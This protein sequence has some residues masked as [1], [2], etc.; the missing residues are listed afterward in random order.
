VSV[1]SYLHVLHLVREAHLG[2][3]LGNDLI[4]HIRRQLGRRRLRSPLRVAAHV[5]IESK[6]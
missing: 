1:S 2:L 4:H 5:E 3:T 6:P